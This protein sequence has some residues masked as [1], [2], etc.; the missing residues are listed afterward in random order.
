MV[1][2]TNEIF[3]VRNNED[4]GK[5]WIDMKKPIPHYSLYVKEPNQI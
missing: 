4:K 1:Y 5:T 2:Y 3:G